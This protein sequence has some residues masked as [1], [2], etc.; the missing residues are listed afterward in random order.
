MKIP[1]RPRGRTIGF[2]KQEEEMRM[3][4]FM[5]RIARIDL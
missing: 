1:T 4:K 3:P 2:G 5:H